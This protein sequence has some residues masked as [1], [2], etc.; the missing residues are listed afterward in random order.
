MTTEQIITCIGIPIVVA[1]ASAIGILYRQLIH[2][3]HQFDAILKETCKLIG[4]TSELQRQTN[5]LLVELKEIMLLCPRRE[6]N[7]P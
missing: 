3:Q 7:G 1:M 2:Q 4:S 5:V 6:N